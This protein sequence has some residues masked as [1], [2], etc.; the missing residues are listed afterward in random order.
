MDLRVKV[1]LM[2]SFAGFTCVQEVGIYNC[3]MLMFKQN[4]FFIPVNVSASNSSTTPE[5]Q[6]HHVMKKT[7]RFHQNYCFISKVLAILLFFWTCRY[8]LV[9]VQHRQCREKLPE[10]QY[11][12]VSVLV[13]VSLTKSQCIYHQNHERWVKIMQHNSSWI[14]SQEQNSFAVPTYETLVGLKWFHCPVACGTAWSWRDQYCGKSWD[15]YVLTR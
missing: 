8:H 12:S 9:L 2:S 1:N 3:L 13:H 14:V 4:V 7:S 6:Q 11:C 5:A 10:V 15:L